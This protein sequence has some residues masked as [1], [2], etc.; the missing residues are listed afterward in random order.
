MTSSITGI[1]EKLGLKI[2]L[3]DTNFESF[4]DEMR[5]KVSQPLKSEGGKGVNVS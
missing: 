2:E 5:A 1:E 3:Q 4:R